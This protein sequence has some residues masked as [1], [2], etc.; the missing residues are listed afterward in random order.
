MELKEDKGMRTE[1]TEADLR[2][3]KELALTMISAIPEGT[4][5]DV[6]LTAIGM[7]VQ[8]AFSKFVK[9]QY[10]VR[11]FED[12]AYFTRQKLSEEVRNAGH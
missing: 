1:P 9:R 6:A 2:K 10:V 7:L 8:S 3:A 5:T 12:F 4:T 11:S